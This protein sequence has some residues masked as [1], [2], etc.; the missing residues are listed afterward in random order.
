MLL[1]KKLE[2][3]LLSAFVFCI[4]FKFACDK[5]YLECFMIFGAVPYPDEGVMLIRATSCLIS[6]KPFLFQP[7]LLMVLPF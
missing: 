2:V 7:C 1:L 4:M 3:F 5:A 6:V